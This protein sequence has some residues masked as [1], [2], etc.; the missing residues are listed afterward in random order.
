MHMIVGNAFTIVVPVRDPDN[1]TCRCRTVAEMA[2]DIGVDDY[3]EWPRLCAQ[4]T[5]SDDQPCPELPK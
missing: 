5:L 2:Q 1:P 3:S 4:G